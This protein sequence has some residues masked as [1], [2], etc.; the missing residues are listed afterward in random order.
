[1]TNANAAQ[2]SLDDILES[3]DRRNREVMEHR[4]IGH[5]PNGIDDAVTRHMEQ[6][7]DYH[8]AMLED[9]R[10]DLAAI[11]AEARDLAVRVQGGQGILAGDGSAGT[12]LRNR[13]AAAPGDVPRWGQAGD[14]IVTTR[15]MDVRIRMDGFFGIGSI[16]GQCT[17]FD[18]IAVDR[19]R[20]FLS[21]TGYRSFL[22]A[23]GEPFGMTVDEFV[24]RAI[25]YQ[26]TTEMKGRL[27]AIEPM[28]RH[29]AAPTLD[30]AGSDSAEG[31][32][33]DD[34]EAEDLE[35][36]DGP[37]EDQEGA[38]DIATAA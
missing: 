4:R 15:G 6:I 26:V 38:G 10:E 11:R 35:D 12:Q 8:R 1:M 2:V 37:E 22:G 27:V 32:A 36:A 30:L 16:G 20:P 13:C 29:E 21:K 9:R 28:R 3:A 18:A 24:Q 14:F 23:F 33:E 19:T 5:L 17:G 31:E 34:G 7:G 25:E